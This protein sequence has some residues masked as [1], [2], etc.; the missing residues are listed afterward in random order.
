MLDSWLI[1][2]RWIHVIAGSTWFG[3]VVVINFILLP[4]LDSLDVPGRRRF[5]TTVFP[6][7][8]R[9]ASVLSATAVVTGLLMVFTITEGDLSRLTQGRWG[10]AI[11]FGGS[12]GTVLTLFHFFMENRLAKR[13]GIGCEYIP[14]DDD[15]ANVHEKLKIVPRGGM[16]VISTIF[17]SMMY[18][19]R[20]I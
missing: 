2:I 20:G 1:P 13:I 6:R 12:L 4:V 9:M 15:L 3:E 19:V 8:F 17:F 11:L 7:V 18:A 16:L 10:H 14:S 5:L